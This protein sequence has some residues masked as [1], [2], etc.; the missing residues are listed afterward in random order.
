ML[1]TYQFPVSGSG[2]QGLLARTIALF[3]IVAIAASLLPHGAR[4][5][6]TSSD[7]VYFD[8]TGQTLGGAFYDA[9]LDQG[10]RAEAGA[11]VSAAVQQGNRWVQWFEHTRLEVSKPTLD[12]AAAEDVQPGTIGMALAESFGLSRWHPAFKPAD[13]NVADGVRA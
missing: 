13:G 5:Q 3:A 11:P 8:G 1:S 4:A 7:L 12:Q 6:E 9:W 2:R 10:G